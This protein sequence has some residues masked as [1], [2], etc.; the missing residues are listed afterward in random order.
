MANPP[1]DPLPL[2]APPAKVIAPP[3]LALFTIEPLFELNVLL[4][5]IS[6]SPALPFAEFAQKV[7]GPL[8][9]WNVKPLA[10]KIF[11]VAFA[12]SP[13]P[14]PLIVT[15]LLKVTLPFAALSVTAPGVV[16]AV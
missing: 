9:V 2:S 12:I 11:P 10:V 6:I 1:G 14:E 16:N 3:P 13:L 15:L 4:V 7:I 5:L 8:F